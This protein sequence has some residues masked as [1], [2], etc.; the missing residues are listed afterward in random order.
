MVDEGERVEPWLLDGLRRVRRW[1]YGY[2]FHRQCRH[3]TLAVLADGR[4]LV[5]STD[6]QVGPRAYRTERRARDVAA[7]LVSSE[8]WVEVPAQYDAYGKPLGDGWRRLGG[9]W[10]R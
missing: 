6:R 3:V 4:W 8:G 7:Q 9:E 5:E 2:I 1:R 10:V